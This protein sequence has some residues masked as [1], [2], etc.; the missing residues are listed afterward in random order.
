MSHDFLLYSGA[1]IVMAWGIAHIIPT[2]SVIRDFGELSEDNRRII[3]MEW[4]AE[5]LALAFVGALAVLVAAFGEPHS[6][7]GVLVL[8][9]CAG[10]LLVLASW[11]FV[12][13]RRTSIVPIRLCPLVLLVS[14]ALLFLGTLR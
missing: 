7:T 6:S 12:A 2:Q 13:G 14:A 1:G 5:G 4:V 3:T 10:M 11:T 9:A 8:R